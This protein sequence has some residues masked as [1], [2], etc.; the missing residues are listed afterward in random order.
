LQVL[1]RWYLHQDESP[2]QRVS[3]CR[4]RQAYS[5]PMSEELDKEQDG[6]GRN[7]PLHLLSLLTT[8]LLTLQTIHQQL[9]R[10]RWKEVQAILDGKYIPSLPEAYS[11][12]GQ[13]TLLN[14]NQTRRR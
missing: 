14:F 5:F 9:G 1:L 4:K 3:L 2:I 10:P 13:Q 6:Q 8:S 12:I 7:F 11:S